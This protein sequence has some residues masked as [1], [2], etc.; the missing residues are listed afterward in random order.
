M[1]SPA[2]CLAFVELL[3]TSCG[4]ALH[5]GLHLQLQVI[6]GILDNDF[7]LCRLRP[8]AFLLSLLLY[9]RLP[10]Q[11]SCISLLLKTCKEISSEPG[12]LLLLQFPL[13]QFF[14]LSCE[15]RL[16][17]FRFWLRLWLWL[18]FR[19][20]CSLRCLLFGLRTESLLPSSL[21]FLFFQLGLQF[22]LD[23]LIVPLI[24]V[25]VIPPHR[26]RGSFPAGGGQAKKRLSGWEKPAGREP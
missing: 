12:I 14:L 4:K 1:G 25:T 2:L 20:R 17:H 22:F 23:V 16:L 19:L 9:L 24:L 8:F 15:L 18:R 26:L 11:L 6:K 13:S 21:F 3:H 10:L 7:R 5:I